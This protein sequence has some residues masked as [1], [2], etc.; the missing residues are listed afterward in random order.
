MVD[1]N[2]TYVSIEDAT[3]SYS[4]ISNTVSGEEVDI[5]SINLASNEK[6]KFRYDSTDN[7]YYFNLSTKG[8]NISS[9]K[10]K[11][12]LNDGRAVKEVKNSLI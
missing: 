12:N 7:Q 5:D 11:I 10:L 3:I 4:F 2:N 1:A 8:F 6:K 9:Y